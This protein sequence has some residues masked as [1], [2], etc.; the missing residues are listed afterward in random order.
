MRIVVF[1]A[2]GNI[3]SSLLDRLAADDR[4]ESVV[5]LAR[6]V[7]LGASTAIGAPW[8]ALKAAVSLGCRARLIS[9]ESGWVDLVRSAPLMDTTAA[10]RELAWSPTRDALEC[11]QEAISGVRRSVPGPTPPLAA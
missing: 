3:G 7:P 4:V 11:L 5:A 8:A 6:R 1:G 9:I 2:T 10:Q